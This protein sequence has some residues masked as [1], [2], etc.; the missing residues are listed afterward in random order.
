MQQYFAI[1][2][3]WRAVKNVKPYRHPHAQL[4]VILA[5]CA[6]PLVPAALSSCRHFHKWKRRFNASQKASLTHMID[7]LMRCNCRANKHL[8]LPSLLQGIAPSK[9][10]QSCLLVYYFRFAFCFSLPVEPQK[11]CYKQQKTIKHKTQSNC[12]GRRCRC[13]CCFCC[14]FCYYLGD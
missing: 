4:S 12:R 5:I 3:V 9:S 11:V 10:C 14:R 7:L 8:L 13:C 6:Y 1:S 2:T